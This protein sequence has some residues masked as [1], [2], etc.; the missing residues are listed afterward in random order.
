MDRCAGILPVPGGSLGTNS[1]NSDT[2]SSTCS[3]AGEA[4]GA[5]SAAISPQVA[6]LCLLSSWFLSQTYWSAVPV[7]MGG[8]AV[9]GCPKSSAMQ[10]PTQVM[11]PSLTPS[12]RTLY[13]RFG[14]AL[15]IQRTCMRIFQCVRGPCITAHV[16]FVIA[17]AIC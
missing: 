5:V 12:S 13:L 7:L 2:R 8:D 10:N 16:Q 11:L 3:C 4:G 1:N 9:L 14:C 6:S 15:P 17:S